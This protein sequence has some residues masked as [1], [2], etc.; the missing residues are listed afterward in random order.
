[1]HGPRDSA[2]GLRDPLIMTERTTVAVI[3]AGSIGTGWAI[4]FAVAGMWARLYDTAEDR[5]A[6]ALVQIAERLDQLC[7]CEL[8]TEPAPSVLARIAVAGELTA[9]VCDAD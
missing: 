9:A 1:M 3:G 5:L 4:L 7:R 2:Q 8:C 6:A